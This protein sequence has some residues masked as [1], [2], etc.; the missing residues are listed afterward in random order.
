[1]VDSAPNV[2]TSEK[3]FIQYLIG[4]IVEK[5]PGDLIANLKDITEHIQETYPPKHE[6]NKFRKSF[7]N[8]KDCIK[9]AGIQAVFRLD[10]TCFKF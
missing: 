1:M 4:Y 7:G 10:G 8:F 2:T 5:N 9:S 3:E 6:L